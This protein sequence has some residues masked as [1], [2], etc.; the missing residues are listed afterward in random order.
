MTYKGRNVLLALRDEKGRVLLQHRTDD[1]KWYP[2][3]WGFFGGGI[4]PGETPEEAVMR[5]AKEELGIE[6]EE[7]KL[8]RVY[9]FGEHDGVY[10]AFVFLAKLNHPVEQL[11]K[12]LMEGQ[13]L[14]LFSQEELR[15]LLLPE[16]S[17][18]ALND[19]FS[20]DRSL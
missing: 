1:A 13:G 17:R 5:E 11:R 9:D 20:Q 7:L 14:G 15:E 10:Q 2:N 4:E 3:H 8:F 16:N 6:L 19:I 18:K 12:Q